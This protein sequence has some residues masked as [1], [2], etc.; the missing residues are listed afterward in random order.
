MQEF[1][2]GEHRYRSR[3]MNARQQFHCVRRLGPLF[4]QL[5]NMAPALAG[6]TPG[7]LGD[8]EAN[9]NFEM[10]LEG[11]TAALAR[12]P[13]ADCDYVIDR[14]MEVTQRLQGGNGSGQATWA[15][16][17]NA[18]LNRM[19][20]EDIELSE[21]FSITGEVLRDNLGG[22]FNTMPAPNGQM[23]SLEQAT[24]GLPSQPSPTASS[25]S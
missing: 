24:Q 12:I 16:I 23:G 17:W 22:F 9:K 11:F 7:T 18:R 3:K 21:M 20:F 8:V 15:D 14:C 10:A 5:L 4:G 1:T 13:D 19:M 25:T 2:I 6:L